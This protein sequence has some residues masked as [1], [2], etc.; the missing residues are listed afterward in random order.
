MSQ[1]FNI[2]DVVRYVDQDL[3]G[4]IELV[5][6]NMNGAIEYQAALLNAEGEKSG[7]AFSA[8]EQSLEA[9][10][11]PSGNLDGGNGATA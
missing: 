8:V 7:G 9:T 5:Q 1:K 3:V 2:G 6:R 11:R 4:E 10:D